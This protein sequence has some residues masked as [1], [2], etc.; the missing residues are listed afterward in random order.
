MISVD[1]GNEPRWRR[2]GREVFYHSPDNRLMAATVDGTGAGFDVG[3]VK[4]LF[5]LSA[6]GPRKFYDVS[7]D[8][9]RFLANLPIDTQPGPTEITVVVNWATAIKN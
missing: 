2:D 8:G 1:G 4:P 9:Q 3:V 6:S 7:H 5:E